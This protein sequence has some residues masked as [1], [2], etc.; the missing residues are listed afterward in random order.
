MKKHKEDVEELEKEQH[1]EHYDECK[2]GKCKHKGKKHKHHH[3]EGCCEH[4]H[5]HSHDHSHG[6]GCGCSEEKD[7]SKFGKVA[8]IIAVVLLIVGFLN[9]IPAYSSVILL[10]SILFAGYDTFLGGIKNIFK[11]NFETN[12]LVFISVIASCVLGEM[13]EAAMLIV[14]YKLGMIIEDKAVEKSYGNIEKIAEIKADLANIVDENGDIYTKNVEIVEIGEE[15]LIKPGEKVPLDC[16]VIKGESSLDTSSITGESD[17][18][19]V[20]QGDSIYSGAINVTGA[21]NCIVEKDYKNSLVS[22]MIDLVYE[23]ANNKGKTEDFINKFSKKYTPTVIILAILISVIPI[24]VLKL[25]AKT[26]IMK[27]L[28]FLVASCPCSIV[29]S[30]PLGLFSAIGALSKKGI[31]VKGTKYLES[32]AN[33]EAIAFDKTGTITTGEKVVDEVEVLGDMKEKNFKDIIYNMERLSNHPIAKAIEKYVEDPDILEIEKFEDK[34]GYG[35]Y[36]LVEGK[37]TLLGN[38]K[39]LKLYD[40]ETESLSD[41]YIYLAIEGKI[42]GYLNFKEQTRKVN[43]L[44]PRLRDVG[45]KRIMMITGDNKEAALKVQKELKLDG[46]TCNVLPDG[47]VKAI[48]KLKEEFK[49]VIFVGDGI[50]DSPVLAE[51]DFGMSMG[52]SAEISNNTADGILIS[53]NIDTIPEIIKIAKKAM[54][55]AR[56][57]IVFSLLVKVV[58]LAIGFVSTVPIWIAVFADTGV[59]VITILNAIRILKEKK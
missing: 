55:I 10:F 34:P 25:E 3:E 22:Q 32:L 12:T 17:L 47:K 26:W 14:L 13:P 48:K 50:N 9:I 21:I 27:S 16:K 5:G 29:I 46:F 42:A 4:S 30:I 44:V 35:I 33:P 11:F 43:N 52:D 20:K 1:H 39:L 24:F 53:N 41:N 23:A 7:N 40:I 2:D 31:I 57:N 38:K 18:A 49:N 58:V 56:F 28:I 51:A 8:F 36:A 54:S 6:H 15:I 19:H 37:E 45:C 59:T